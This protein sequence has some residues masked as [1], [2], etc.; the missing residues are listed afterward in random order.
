[1]AAID[2]G[3]RIRAFVQTWFAVGVVV[4]LLATLVGGW[5]AYQV[6]VVPD[7]AEEERLVEQWDESTAYDHSASIEQ[8]SVPFEEGEVVSNRPI[9]YTN[10]SSGLNGTYTYGYSAE[11]GD[12]SVTTE[13]LLLIRAGELEDQRVVETYWEVAEPLES[14][15]ADSVGPSDEHAVEF[16]VNVTDVLETIETVERQVGATEGLVDVRVVSVTDVDGT[17]EGESHADTYESE[18]IMVVDPA[19]FRVIETDTITEDHPSFETVQ[20]IAEPSP[21][22]VYGSILLFTAAFVL[23]VALSFARIG[24]YTDLSENEQ[25]LLRLERDRAQYDDWI[26]TG[27][28]PSEREYEQTVLVDDLEGLTDVAI[29]TNKRVIEDT[30]LGV[31]TVLDDEYIYL[32][33]H[34]NSPAR[35]WLVNYADTTLEEFEANAF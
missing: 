22:E 5:W 19:T 23:L 12:V 33:V 7:V 8:D 4:L 27:K 16:S 30:Q 26:T 6:N 10:L 1:M 34:P 9:Y 21:H 28:F 18:M 15:S 17:V 25:E 32:Y 2:R 20:L 13:T 31:S 14:T 24:G 3:V 35:D 29:D 11:D